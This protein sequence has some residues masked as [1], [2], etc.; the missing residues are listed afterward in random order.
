MQSYML[1]ESTQCTV[2][3]YMIVS[4]GAQQRTLMITNRMLVEAVESH[5]IQHASI[6]PSLLAL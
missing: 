1:E 6:L 4:E 2:I 5:Y 3:G